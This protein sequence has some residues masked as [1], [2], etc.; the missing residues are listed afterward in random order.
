MG[1][2]VTAATGQVFHLL[3]LR[4]LITPQDSLVGI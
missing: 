3:F 1:L 4:E 2:Y